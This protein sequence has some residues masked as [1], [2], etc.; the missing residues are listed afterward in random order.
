M[1]ECIFCN[2]I[3]GET[4]LE[5]I[6]EDKEVMAIIHPRPAVPG[7]IFVFPKNHY[8]IFEQLLKIYPPYYQK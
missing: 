3:K 2:A 8:Q 4:E 6:Y 1:S 7:H 5:V